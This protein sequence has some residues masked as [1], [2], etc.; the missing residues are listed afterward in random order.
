ME[1]VAGYLQAIREGRGI[2]RARVAE[3]TGYT[4]NTIWRVER[5]R[6]EPSGELLFKFAYAISGN[7]LDIQTLILDPAATRATGEHLAATRL[8]KRDAD[9]IEAVYRQRMDY[10]ARLEPIWNDPRKFRL[11]MDFIELLQF[12]PPPRVTLPPL[13]IPDAPPA[14]PQPTD[15]P[16]PDAQSTDTPT[17]DTPTPDAQSTDTHTTPTQTRDPQPTDAQN[18]GE[19]TS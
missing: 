10:L 19:P 15:T 16:T 1:A 7:L 4:E 14:D 13:P 6:Q 5:T 17:M 18:D 3:L 8:G 12:T 11:L 9:D 2:S